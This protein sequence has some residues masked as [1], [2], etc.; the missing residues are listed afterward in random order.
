MLS[1]LSPLCTQTLVEVEVS[2]HLIGCVLF[3]NSVCCCFLFCC[4]FFHLQIRVPSGLS[5]PVKSKDVIV[6]FHKQVQ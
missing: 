3:N 5:V 4:L 6:D 2:Y 1:V